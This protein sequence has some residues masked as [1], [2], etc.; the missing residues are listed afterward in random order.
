MRI[1][2]TLLISAL[3]INVNAQKMKEFIVEIEVNASNEAVW[4]TITDFENYPNWNSVL[5]MKNN[6]SLIIGRKFQVSIMQ[7][8]GKKSNFK[9]VAVN[10]D[11]FNSFS[12]TQTMIGKWLFEATHFFII[13]E[14]DKKN[15]NFIQKWELKGLIAS[16]FFKQIVKELE[17]F[18]EMNKDLKNYIER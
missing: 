9:A 7:P 6:D 5:L 13:K 11:E 10:K 8:N 15:V 4:K 2:F 14:V 1:L 16:L 17:V 12:A 3:S 18:K